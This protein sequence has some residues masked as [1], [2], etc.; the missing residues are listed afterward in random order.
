VGCCLL[1]PCQTCFWVKCTVYS[2]YY[3][4]IIL[5]IRS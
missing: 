5:Y 4:V 1:K 3:H 2:V